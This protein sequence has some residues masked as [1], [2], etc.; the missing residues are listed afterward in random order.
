MQ[1][2][3]GCGRAMS[4]T[5]MW[6]IAIGAALALGSETKAQCPGEGSCYIAHPTPGCD[7]SGCCAEVCAVDAFCCNNSW[8][9]ICVNEAVELC[10]NCGNPNAGNCYVPHEGIGCNDATCC[11]LV[12]AADPFCCNTEWDSICADAAIKN[13]SNCGNPA[14]GNCY[15]AHA[16]VGCNVADCCNLVCG[17][18]PFCC[19]SSWDGICAEE[20][21]VNCGDCG[22]PESGNCY[23]ADGTPGCDSGDCCA[24]ICALDPFCCNNSWDSLC[25]GAAADLCDNCGN[26]AAGSCFVAHEGI[27]CNDAECCSQVCAEDPFCCESAWDSICAN[28]ALEVCGGCGDPSSGNCYVAHSGTGCDNSTCCGAVCAVDPFCCETS[29]DSICAGEAADL[30]NNCGNP[31]AGPCDQA[32]ANIGCSDAAC[33]ET[34]C[35]LDPFCCNSE[36][37]GICVGEAL[38]NCYSCGNPLA[39]NCYEFHETPGCNDAKCCDEVCAIDP[40]CCNNTWDGICVNEALELCGNCGGPGAGP[41][42]QAHPGPGCANFDCCASVCAIDPFCCNVSW[43]NLCASEAIDL[44]GCVA[45]IAPPN[46]DGVVNTDDLLLVINSWG[47]CPGCDADVAPLGGNGFVNTD[48][49]LVIINNW[50]ACD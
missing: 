21:A 24:E 32:H 6:L 36:W 17:F 40:F 29:W 47:P 7:N 10:D 13:C 5:C 28:S 18:D 1:G 23:Q 45:D 44:C 33:C 25:A 8:D 43:D 31:N 12:C 16:G 27:G 22:A 20:A 15:A 42:G 39:S 37:D 30:C 3:Q 48:D 9:S 19:D 2:I 4:W 38:T 26:P 34:V 11:S 41:C 14:A 49:L 50:G 46:G 35:A